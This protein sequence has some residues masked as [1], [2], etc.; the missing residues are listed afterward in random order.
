MY[1]TRKD[2]KSREHVTYY[3]RNNPKLFN[4][5]NVETS[6]ELDRSQWRVTIDYAEDFQLVSEIFSQLYD[7]KSFIKFN[8]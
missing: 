2:P 3:I 7:G 5:G 1:E 4:I 6:H 8:H